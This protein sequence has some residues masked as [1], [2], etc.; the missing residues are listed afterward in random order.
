MPRCKIKKR[1]FPTT[2]K[3]QQ[4]KEKKETRGKMSELFEERM[5]FNMFMADDDDGNG[6][7]IAIDDLG[8]KNEQLHKDD[9]DDENLSSS[10]TDDDDVVLNFFGANCSVSP[11]FTDISLSAPP[12]LFPSDM[13]LMSEFESSWNQCAPMSPSSSPSS[14][15]SMS[16]SSSSDRVYSAAAPPLL[17]DK[18]QMHDDDEKDAL[19]Q[20]IFAKQEQVEAV[21]VAAVVDDD[22]AAEAKVKA[23]TRGRPRRAAASSSASSK[24]RASS[25]TSRKRQRTSSGE[26]AVATELTLPRATILKMSSAEMDAF[27]SRKAVELGR[28]F[29]DDEEAEIRRQRR[30]IKNRES[31][32][33]SRRRKK[34]E[35]NELTE[36]NRAL[37]SENAELHARVERLERENRD[38]RARLKSSTAMSIASSVVDS[39]AGIARGI[40]K[41]SRSPSGAVAGVAL[42]VMLFSFGLFFSPPV[43]APRLFV[44]NDGLMGFD[45]SSFVLGAGGDFAFAPPPAPADVLLSGDDGVG[46]RPIGGRRMLNIDSFE[47]R[48][49]PDSGAANDS[50][51][52]K[53]SEGNTFVEPAAFE[54]SEGVERATPPPATTSSHANVSLAS[55]AAQRN[56][57]YVLCSS[58][59]SGAE[60]DKSLAGVL[61]DGMSSSDELSFALLVPENALR[62]RLSS[63][64][65]DTPFVEVQCHVMPRQSDPVYR[66][67]QVDASFQM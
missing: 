38:L 47:A 56:I 50:L 34:T 65:A 4:K 21:P 19:F 29:N 52:S 42:M 62:Q 7:A 13:V 1:K 49:W 9:D 18:V 43:G 60:S 61:D 37:S 58:V 66:P 23:P 14:P 20:T 22:N 41:D 28:S 35:V 26:P 59:E 6:N 33:A 11:Q 36:A 40:G 16:P 45:D 51:P 30:Q 44:A 8:N 27:V 10:S 25:A 2:K 17:G 32:S 54:L 57:T 64:S 55:V 5:L 46:D 31:A 39:F 15:G 48:S 53:A 67:N 3:K 63:A 12:P 24:A